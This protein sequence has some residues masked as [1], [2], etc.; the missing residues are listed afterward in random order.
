MPP[1]N[2][3]TVTIDRKELLKELTE[4]SN[5]KV[6]SNIVREEVSEKVKDSK[7]RMLSEFNNHPVTKEIDAGPTASNTSNTLG[8][9]GNLFSFIG[10]DRGDNPTQPVKDVLS[11]KTYTKIRRVAKRGSYKVETNVPTKSEL[12]NLGPIP[13]AS[14]MSW[15]RGIE[16]GISG[17]GRYFY[18]GK[19]SK[20]SRSG[21]GVQVTNDSGRSFAPTDYLNNIYR[22]FRDRIR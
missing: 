17:L 14:G 20:V 18:K 11:R 16:K 4:G 13:W 6:V 15:I 8:G 12:E 7:E 3:V 2:K 19:F 22:R 9:Y 21:T 10:F 5:D 1:R